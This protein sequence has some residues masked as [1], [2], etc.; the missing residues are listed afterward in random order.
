MSKKTNC[1]VLQHP[2]C[3][4][5]DFIARFIQNHPDQKH[6]IVSS[7]SDF[8]QLLNKNVSQ[9]N[10]IMNQHITVDGVFNDR[11]KPVIDKKTGEQK[12]IGR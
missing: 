9:Y 3:E 10:G 12:Q 8:Y 1:S 5:D 4:A 11:G 2:E 6:V 7:D